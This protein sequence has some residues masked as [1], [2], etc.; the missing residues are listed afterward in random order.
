MQDLDSFNLDAVKRQ[1]EAMLSNDSVVILELH[2]K[3]LR[4][5]PSGG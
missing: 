1:V 3:R 5:K 2:G 4:P